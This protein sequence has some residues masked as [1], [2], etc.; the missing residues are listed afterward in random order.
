MG[1]G[2]GQAVHRQLL[3]QH[4]DMVHEGEGLHLG[5]ADLGQAGQGLLG[6]LHAGAPGDVVDHDGQVG[7]LDDGVDVPVDP[8]LAGAVVVGSVDEQALGAGLLFVNLLR[9]G[10]GINATVESLDA[11]SVA[12]IAGKAHAQSV[13]E[14][15][16]NIIPHSAVDAF[17]KG[18]LIQVMFFSVLVGM[19]LAMLG[20]KEN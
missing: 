8:L 3:A 10:D 14:I 6:D 13:M 1:G 11:Q 17:A 9:P 20:K 19:G 4:L 2:G 16:A 18:D 12:T 15:I 7:G 5:E